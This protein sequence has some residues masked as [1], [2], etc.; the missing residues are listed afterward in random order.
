[1]AEKASET[2]IVGGGDNIIQAGDSDETDAVSYEDLINNAPETS[3]TINGEED[4][5]NGVL[6]FVA[7]QVPGTSILIANING[8]ETISVQINQLSE[9]ANIVTV[10]AAAAQVSQTSKVNA[11]VIDENIIQLSI[12]DDSDTPITM[13]A[14]SSM[15]SLELMQ[16]VEGVSLDLSADSTPVSPIVDVQVTRSDGGIDTIVGIEDVLGSNYD[17]I[18]TGDN[19]I[20]KLSGGV[21]QDILTGGAG[22]D[23]L[24]VPALTFSA[25]VMAM[26]LYAGAGIDILSGGGEDILNN[27]DANWWTGN[28]TFI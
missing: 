4:A 14:V 5:A 20:N 2:F 25:A 9:L 16:S 27:A 12:A 1:M 3:Q 19:G 6:K 28:D 10:I 13:S 11:E 15:F 7:N 21:G 23:V 24:A 8:S 18:I 17:D 26:I 22:D